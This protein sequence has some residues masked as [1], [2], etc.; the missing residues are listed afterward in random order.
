MV[1]SSQAICTVS[2]PASVQVVPGLRGPARAAAAAA[3]G[4]LTW[5]VSK[6]PADAAA[7]PCARSVAASRAAFWCTPRAMPASPSGPW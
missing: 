1:V 4:R 5:T 6:N 7:T 3:P 2:G